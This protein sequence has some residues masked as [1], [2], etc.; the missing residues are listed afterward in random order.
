MI[1]E[2]DQRAWIGAKPKQNELPANP[3]PL[4]FTHH[5]RFHHAKTYPLLGELTSALVLSVSQEF[6]DAALIGGKTDNLAGDLT[7]ESGTAG[8]LALGT[9]DPGLGGVKRG[10]LLYGRSIRS[11]TVSVF[12]HDRNFP[13]KVVKEHSG[14]G[15][16]FD[17]AKSVKFEFFSPSKKVPYSLPQF[18]ESPDSFPESMVTS[19]VST[20][21]HPAL[22]IGKSSFPCIFSH[23]RHF[24]P[25][26][27]TGSNRCCRRSKEQGTTYVTL[28]EADHDSGAFLSHHD[29]YGLRLATT[30]LLLRGC[31]VDV[32]RCGWESRWSLPVFGWPLRECV[33]RV[34]LRVAAA[35]SRVIATSYRLSLISY[36]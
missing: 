25:P 36:R 16:R 35:L 11:A 1:V 21:I 33:A 6:D 13:C 5:Q 15:A 20:I 22:G 9:A 8:R 24:F 34:G 26:H 23:S 7:N 3:F 4:P 14:S 32:R 18:H 30:V 10:G 29:G 19:V 2:D 17:P 12:L 31:R 27:S 28:V